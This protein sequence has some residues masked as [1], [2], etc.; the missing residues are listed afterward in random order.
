MTDARPILAALIAAALAAPA[1]YAAPSVSGESTGDVTGTDASSELMIQYAWDASGWQ[2]AGDSTDD[3]ADNVSYPA[4]TFQVSVPKDIS[5][6]NM[7]AGAVDASCD[8]TVRA[9]GII[10]ETSTLEV[11]VDASTASADG[12]EIAASVTQGKASLTPTELRGGADGSLNPDGSLKG[13]SWTD[14]AELSGHALAE[15]TWEV[16]CTYTATV[17]TGA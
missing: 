16:D 10:P 14:R 11:S 4:G 9:R 2:D 6:E 13:V 3:A 12:T 7:R 15:G 5:F 17:Q 1:A 8:Y